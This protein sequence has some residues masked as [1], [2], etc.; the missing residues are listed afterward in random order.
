MFCFV[1]G[2]IEKQLGDEYCMCLHENEIESAPVVALILEVCYSHR[3][4]VTSSQYR[5]VSYDIA[6]SIIHIT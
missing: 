4:P 6:L 1:R 2:C 5:W 3:G